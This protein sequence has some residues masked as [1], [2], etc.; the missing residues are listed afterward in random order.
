[1]YKP[2]DCKYE[3]SMHM[4]TEII[5]LLINVYFSYFLSDSRVLSNPNKWNLIGNIGIGLLVVIFIS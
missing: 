5:L 1:M 4:I 3:N 2:F